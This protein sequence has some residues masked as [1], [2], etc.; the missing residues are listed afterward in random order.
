[1]FGE[2]ATLPI[3]YQS[4]YGVLTEE[5]HTFRDRGSLSGSC[6]TNPERGSGGSPGVRTNHDNHQRAGRNRM[7]YYV[8]SI[9]YVCSFVVTS[10]LR[11]SISASSSRF[12]EILEDW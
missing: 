8:E 12:I 4:R 2:T 11:R 7:H 10:W 9:G 6:C 1:M 3:Y 5:M